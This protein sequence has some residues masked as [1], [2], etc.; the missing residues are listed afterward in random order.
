M[1]EKN[2]ISAYERTMSM[3]AVSRELGLSRKMVMEYVMEYI[4]A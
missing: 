1:V 4:S 2:I 3:R